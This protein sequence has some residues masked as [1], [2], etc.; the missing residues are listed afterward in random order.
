MSG[1]DS[2]C[3]D[4]RPT[5]FGDSLLFSPRPPFC[6]SASSLP[7]ERLLAKC[8]KSLWL[9]ILRVSIMGSGFYAD[10]LVFS[11]IY[12]WAWEGGEIAVGRGCRMPRIRAICRKG[13]IQQEPEVGAP[14]SGRELMAYVYGQGRG[15]IGL[16]QHAATLAAALCQDST[17]QASYLPAGAPGRSNQQ[18]RRTRCGERFPHNH[19][20]NRPAFA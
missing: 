18:G 13:R 17:R 1:W 19:E 16:P 6:S 4:R 9:K 20:T 11:R 7:P 14:R 3:P 8:A 10:A 5:D 12:G 2:P 15:D